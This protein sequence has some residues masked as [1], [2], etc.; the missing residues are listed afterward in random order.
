LLHGLQ[1]L[2]K[3]EGQLPPPPPPTARL[4]S[5]SAAKNATDAGGDGAVEELPP[6]QLR[7]WSDNLFLGKVSESSLFDV[8]PHVHH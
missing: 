4:V 2:P 7:T 3:L 8:S 6:V 1:N 5:D